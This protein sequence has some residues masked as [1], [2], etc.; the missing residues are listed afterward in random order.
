ML[1][2]Y[3]TYSRKNRGTYVLSKFVE[4]LRFN[5]S[6]AL[7]NFVLAL[8]NTRIQATKSGILNLFLLLST[9]NFAFKNSIQILFSALR[10]HL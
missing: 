8:A 1:L 10:F 2:L 3:E 6:I 7:I 4:K 5:I 9:D